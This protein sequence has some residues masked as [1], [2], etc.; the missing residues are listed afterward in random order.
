MWGKL[1]CILINL[2]TISLCDSYLHMSMLSTTHP[3]GCWGR[4]GCLWPRTEAAAVTTRRKRLSV[5]L[6]LSRPPGNWALC[7]TM[8]VTLSVTMGCGIQ[9]LMTLSLMSQVAQSQTSQTVFLLSVCCLSDE[10]WSQEWSQTTEWTRAVEGLSPRPAHCCPIVKFPDRNA[11]RLKDLQSINPDSEIAG[12]KTSQ[13]RAQHEIQTNM[14]TEGKTLN[15]V[16]R[17]PLLPVLFMVMVMPLEL[18]NI[19][20]RMMGLEC[21]C[22]LGSPTRL[23]N[24]KSLN[25]AQWVLSGYPWLNPSLFSPDEWRQLRE[26]VTQGRLDE[27]SITVLHSTI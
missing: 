23:R 7:V 6:T 4:W 27:D 18:R 17:S 14:E 9:C 16:Y 24:F 22:W 25:P 13:R 5:M 10:P 15:S 20:Y 8:C 26:S 11:W 21:N 3:R 19:L 12:I 2:S 1:L